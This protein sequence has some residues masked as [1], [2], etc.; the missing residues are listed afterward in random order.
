MNLSLFLLGNICRHHNTTLRYSLQG[1]WTLATLSFSLHLSLHPH[2]QNFSDRFLCC[3][4][5]CVECLAIISATGHGNLKQSYSTI[6]CTTISCG[7]TVRH[8]AKLRISQFF[9]QFLVSSTSLLS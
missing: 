5:S 6:W 4:S 3:Q 9:H 7:V 1:H 8:K 2:N